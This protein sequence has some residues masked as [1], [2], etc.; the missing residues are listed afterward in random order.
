MSNDLGEKIKSATPA[1]PVEIL[2]LSGLPSAGDTFIIFD[3]EKKAKELANSRKQK[4]REIQLSQRK[5]VSLETLFSEAKDQKA[6]FN[7]LLKTDTDGSLGALCDSLVKLSNDEVKIE[8][9]GKGVGGINESDAQLANASKAVI[10]GFNV[11]ADKKA[12]Q[13]IDTN[14]TDLYYFSI[15]YD[16]INQ[17]KS[18]VLGLMQPTIKENILGYAQ[19]RE[20]FS[21]SKFGSI[22]GCMVTE[23]TLRR[24]AKVR[25]LRDDV[26][27]FEGEIQSLRR[28]KNDVAEVRNGMECGIGVKNY[29]DIR[30]KD[31]IE[32]FIT[33]TVLPTLES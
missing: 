25:V 9:V 33:E 29:K 5:K 22:A 26:V 3:N 10:F 32:A 31:Q 17:V 21:S 28:F 15:I 18:G 30:P 24:N 12:K 7:I 20:V 8:I 2:G 14:G 19:V 13:I 4:T 6:V 16:L 1:M 27:I 23:G 11:R